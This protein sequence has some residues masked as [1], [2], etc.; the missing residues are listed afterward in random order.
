MSLEDNLA[1]PTVINYLYLR[2]YDPRMTRWHESLCLNPD[3]IVVDGTPCCIACKAAAP[4]QKLMSAQPGAISFPAVPLDEPSDQMNL[5]WPPSVPYS[6]KNE[7][8]IVTEVTAKEGSVTQP[9]EASV[10]SAAP[11][12][13]AA[14][15]IYLKP[16][17][18]DEFRL[19]FL[20]A[21]NVDDNPVH[22][23]LETYTCGNCPEYEAVSYTW[24]G[25]NDD[26]SPCRPIFVGP[27]W[28]VL[29]QT[30]NCWEMLRY[31]RPWRGHRMIWVDAIC[32]DQGDIVE[33]ARQVENM[34]RIYADC[35]RVIIYLGSDIVLRTPGSHPRRHRLHELEAGTVKLQF[36]NDYSGPADLSLRE[37]LKRR[38]FS[39][40]W[41]IQELVLSQRS[42]MPVGDVEFWTD[43]ATSDYLVSALPA[44]KHWDWE[45]TA[46]PWLQHMS[47]RTFKSRDVTSMMRLTS[48]ASAGDPRDRLFGLLGLLQDDDMCDI[49]PDY[50]L[51]CQHVFV[52]LFSYLLTSFKRWGFLYNVSRHSQSPGPSWVP[53]WT[54]ASAWREIFTIP[55]LDQKEI[56]SAVWASYLGRPA[57]PSDTHPQLSGLRNITQDRSGET[58]PSLVV[59]QERRWDRDI[60]VDSGTGALSVYLTHFVTI[61]STPKRIASLREYGIF[62]IRGRECALFLASRDPLP[63]IVS[64]DVDCIFLLGP[65]SRRDAPVYLILRPTS[66]ARVYRFICAVP[67]VT[68]SIPHI[69]DFTSPLD[70]DNIQQSL[71]FELGRIPGTISTT[72]YDDRPDE[73]ALRQMFPGCK[74]DRAHL[75]AYLRIHCEGD[76]AAPQFEEL[77]LGFLGNNFTPKIDG[78]FVEFAFRSEDWELVKEYYVPPDEGKSYLKL[79]PDYLS[80]WHILP[81]EWRTIDTTWR[82]MDASLP[83]WD[84]WRTLA[85]SGHQQARHLRCSME[86]IRGWF[87]GQYG[88]RLGMLY[89]VATRLRRA[90]SFAGESAVSMI[91]R[92]PR[93]ED[94]FIACPVVP[95]G[96][97]DAIDQLGI[98]GNTYKVRIV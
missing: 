27:Y 88:S 23:S 17:G 68:Y 13:S 75:R 41:V 66:D 15:E 7:Q 90:E 79:W 12:P 57:K 98:N 39:R 91:S 65:D 6:G 21:A 73:I 64:R 53:D 51:S 95:A 49:R 11:T 71:H 19:I 55:R 92:E 16:L 83:V 5:R 43:P 52:G 93:W 89:G 87:A 62:E 34:R 74:T 48:K 22:L 24:G 29:M 96:V 84:K 2:Y 3:V 76:I 14:P 54:S 1:F 59:Q 47:K 72:G 61:Q 58:H 10:E 42:V 69:D 70:L 18:T 32:I 81:W 67:S 26:S 20:P 35:L 78:G 86:A 37:L 28:D 80:C 31:V 44:G 36:P 38:Y 9:N 60:E 85:A 30:E 4:T 33:R 45:E 94:H 50:S 25:E 82:R 77:Y 40:L 97:D 46:A 8:F 56:S 63:S